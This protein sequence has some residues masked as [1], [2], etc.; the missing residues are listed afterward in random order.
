MI[1]K[2]TTQ[3]NYKRLCDY[4]EQA[5]RAEHTDVRKKLTLN[6]D[7]SFHDIVMRL[8]LIEGTTKTEIIRRAINNYSELFGDELLFPTSS[9]SAHAK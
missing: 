8:A 6:L 7:L 4:D 9:L 2:T 5:A 1:N 3:R